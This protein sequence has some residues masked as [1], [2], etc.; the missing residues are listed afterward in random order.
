[1]PKEPDYFSDI[2]SDAPPPL[3]M[4]TDEM[5][6]WLSELAREDADER[7]TGMSLN[8]PRDVVAGE[9]DEEDILED[10]LRRDTESPRELRSGSDKTMVLSEGGFGDIVPGGRSGD[11]DTVDTPKV[12]KSKSKYLRKWSRIF[13][14][15]LTVTPLSAGT[16]NGEPDL[17]AP[18]AA[19]SGSGSALTSSLKGSV[20][21]FRRRGLN[22]ANKPGRTQCWA[23]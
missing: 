16:S 22:S 14:E 12:L 1:M 17:S 20:M 11:I 3:R 15:E 18:T 9:L 4:T 6:E 13:G 8:C 23:A 19:G 5:E 7:A 2:F 21:Q 10:R